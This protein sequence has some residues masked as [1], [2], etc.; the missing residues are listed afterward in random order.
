MPLKSMKNTFQTELIFGT[1]GKSKR[2]TCRISISFVEV[3]R[4]RTFLL[5]ENEKDFVEREAACSLK[6]S[7]L[8]EK[9]SLGIYSLKTLKVS[10]ARIKAGISP[11]YS[12][13]WGTLGTQSNGLFITQKISESR[14][15]GNECSLSDIL[16]E[17]PDQKY[18]LSEKM[19][20]YLMEKRVEKGFSKVH[21]V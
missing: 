18:F 2:K 21:V 9:N 12:L 4:A 5:P 6:S 10:L 16:D 3:S 19:V 1:S 20:K 13:N 7:G 11:G 14:R 15:T 8:Y 17:N